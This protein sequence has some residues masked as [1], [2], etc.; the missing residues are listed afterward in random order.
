ME[1]KY[2]KCK[3]YEINGGWTPYLYSDKEKALAKLS[4][5]LEDCTCEKDIVI[6]VNPNGQL[7]EDFD[8]DTQTSKSIQNM[9]ARG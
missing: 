1:L 4:E 3:L 6:S 7:V 2:R 5:L 9:I 8:E